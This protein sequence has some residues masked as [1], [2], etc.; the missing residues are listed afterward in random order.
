MR[1][2]PPAGTNP[3]P[4]RSHRS[5]S[6]RSTTERAIWISLGGSR[7]SRMAVTSLPG[8]ADAGARAAQ[9]VELVGERP[10][11]PG[12]GVDVQV[13][14]GVLAQ[15]GARTRLRGG[16][17]A[18]RGGQMLSLVP[19]CTS[20]GQ[21][22]RDANLIGR[23]SPASSAVRAHSSFRQL[24]PAM[25]VKASSP[26]ALTMIAFEPGSPTIGTRCGARPASARSA[27]RSP[28][29]AARTR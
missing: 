28:L 14:D 26:P 16:A 2:D 1:R 12:A 27:S 29:P 15:L 13:V 7:P 3:N 9:E 8:R 5:V 25:A 20:S 22:T 17:A 18:G 21:L 11:L 23:L 6:R 10:L 24:G 19:T 4:S